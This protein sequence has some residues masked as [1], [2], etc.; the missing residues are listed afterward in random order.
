MMR[1]QIIQNK[2]E[3]LDFKMTNIELETL[4]LLKAACREYI[5][6]KTSKTKRRKEQ[7]FELTKAILPV[8]LNRN[9]TLPAV[10]LISTATHIA[11]L[12][13]NKLDEDEN[14]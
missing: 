10:D 6:E 11:E 9:P 2:K 12:T 13:L 5:Q 14:V 1:K 3:L 7:K 8:L 4:S